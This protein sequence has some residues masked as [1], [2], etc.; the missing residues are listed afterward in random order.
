MATGRTLLTTTFALT[1]LTE[2]SR[3]AH[4]SRI[5][6]TSGGP[7]AAGHVPALIIPYKAIRRSGTRTLVTRNGRAPDVSGRFKRSLKSV[8]T[9]KVVT[10]NRLVRG[11]ARRPLGPPTISPAWP[12]PRGLFFLKNEAQSLGQAGL[13]RVVRP[14]A[15]A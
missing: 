1:A 15:Q 3:P 6:L 5:D 7:F 11:P 12:S 2:H 10:R 9:T 4:A 13:G 14:V 8:K